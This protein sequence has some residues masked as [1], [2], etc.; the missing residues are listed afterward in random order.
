M[1]GMLLLMRPAELTPAPVLPRRKGQLREG[2]RYAARTHR[3]FGCPL[4]MMAVVGL[5]AFNF[6][7][8]LPAVARFTF[9]GTQPHTH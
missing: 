1:V 3:T 6:T 8:V 4:G 2:L 5:L 9:D 7:V